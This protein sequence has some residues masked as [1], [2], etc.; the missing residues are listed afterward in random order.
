MPHVAT[1]PLVAAGRY[2]I[3]HEG[4]ECGQDR[5]RLERTPRGVVA[6]SE[7]VVE[8]PHPHPQRQEYR[9]ELTTEPRTRVAGLEI[10][11]TVGQRTVR[12][13]HAADGPRWRA[14]IEVQGKVREQQGDYPEACE[15]DFG[16]PLFNMFT[17]SRY[18]FQPGSEI[19]FPV[20]VIGPPF[21]AVTPMRQKYRCVESGT[22]ELPFGRVPGRRFV[23]SDPERPES[24][25]IA[26]WA[27]EHDVVL[28]SWQGLDASNPWM[29]LVDYARDPGGEP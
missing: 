17:L 28:E 14:R 6:T 20:L 12:A 26:F 27:D 3:F 5:W 29:R 4:R 1:T 7:Q 11:W 10:L 23:M 16:T 13:M 22:L 25:A 9:V 2:A 15:V 19:E 24:A 21:M 8:A 18:S